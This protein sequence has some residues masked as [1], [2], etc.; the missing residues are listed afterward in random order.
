[1]R[2]TTIWIIAI[3]VILSMTFVGISCKQAS[4]AETTVSETTV[5]E[6]TVAETTAA[7]EAVVQETQYNFAIVIYDTTGNPWWKKFVTGVEEMSAAFNVKSDIQYANNDPEQQI[8]IMETAIT[9]K[10]NGIGFAIN[11]DGAYDEITQKGVDAGIPML[12]FNIDD[13]KGAAG[14]NPRI[15]FIGQDFVASGYVLGKAMIKE[16]GLKEGDKI[17]CPVEHPEAIYATTRFEGVMKAMNEVG[18]KGEMLDTGAI[19][20]EDTLTKLTQ[21]LIG[22]PEVKAVVGLGGMPT[23]I[24]PQAIADANMSIPSGGFDLSTKILQNI[25]DGKMLGTIDQKPYFQGSL[26][27]YFLWA[28]NKYGLEPPNVNTGSLAILQKAAAEKTLPLADTVR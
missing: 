8:N 19:S 12:A 18:V 25:I 22:H 6:T 23:E 28:Y 21:Y 24:A 27:V 16:Y 1:M 11:I 20:M 15:A 10:V 13:S 3:V 4:T 7:G 17:V 9:Q 26:T 2:K 5:S 14:N